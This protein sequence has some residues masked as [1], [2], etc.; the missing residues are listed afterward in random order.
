MAIGEEPAD[1]SFDLGAVQ[2]PDRFHLTQGTAGTTSVTLALGTDRTPAFT[3]TYDADA[4]D[5]TGQS[6]ALQSCTGGVQAGDLVAAGFA[7]LNIVGGTIPMKIEAQLARNP[8][9]DLLGSGVIPP[10]P[11][12]W[13]DFVYLR[14]RSLANMH[15]IVHSRR[16]TV[17]FFAAKLIYLAINIAVPVLVGLSVLLL[18]KQET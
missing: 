2:V 1:Q 9:G 12:F 17:L 3:C 5:R 14:E 4:S 11:T 18:K 16:D 15:D 8:V 6:Y 7:H 13:G 10:M